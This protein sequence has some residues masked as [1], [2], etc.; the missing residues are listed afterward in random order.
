MFNPRQDIIK[1]EEDELLEIFLLIEKNNYD[2]SK[3][4]GIR[5]A[6]LKGIKSMSIAFKEAKL[7]YREFIQNNK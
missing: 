2:S 4:A 7:K 5:Y 3:E 6:K 1:R